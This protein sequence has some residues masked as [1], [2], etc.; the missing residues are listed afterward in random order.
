M[1][2]ASS[3]TVTA[4]DL[5]NP[6]HAAAVLD[7]LE[8]YACDPMGGGEG[9]ADAVHDTLIP[10]LRQLNNYYAGLVWVGAGAARQAV[11]LINCITGFSTFAAKPL[12]NV[13]DLAVR[14]G[15]RGQGVGQALLAFA[16]QQ[17]RHL[18]CC[19]V[20]LEVLSGNARAMASYE[21]AGFAP[22]VLDPAAGQALFLQKKL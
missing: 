12:L 3:F 4:V 8:H 2:A 13:H 17:A 19:K 11:G 5:N 10:A 7:L 6:E 18:G 22:Y 20:T 14:D 16:E 1:N 15:W 21:R 9:L